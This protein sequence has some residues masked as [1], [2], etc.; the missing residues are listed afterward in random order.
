MSGHQGST[1]AFD[2]RSIKVNRPV[3]LHVAGA[4]CCSTRGRVVL[5]LELF[6]V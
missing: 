1:L 4:L 3:I 2:K 5:Q 6:R